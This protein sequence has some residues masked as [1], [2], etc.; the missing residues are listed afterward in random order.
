MS[1]EFV[2]GGGAVPLTSLG[3]KVVKSI[4]LGMHGTWQAEV[5]Y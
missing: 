3:G 4:T 5:L 1:E 2:V